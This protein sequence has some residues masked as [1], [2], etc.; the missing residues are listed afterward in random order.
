MSRFFNRFLGT[1]FHR[2]H[3]R[4]SCVISRSDNMTPV[5]Q[6]YVLAT[7][8]AF[9]ANVLQILQ[10]SSVQVFV[11][12]KELKRLMKTKVTTTEAGEV[13]ETSDEGESEDKNH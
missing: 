4:T 3:A 7:L 11:S 5:G 2:Y 6:P 8:P 10:S 12:I 13:L 1:P 9:A